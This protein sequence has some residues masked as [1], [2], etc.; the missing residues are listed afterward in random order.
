MRSNS[1]NSLSAWTEY[2][3]R[4]DIIREHAGIRDSGIAHRLQGTL[5]LATVLQPQRQ[6]QWGRL[7]MAVYVTAKQVILG[8]G[9]TRAARRE[10]A[11][12]PF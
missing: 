4:L 9:H 5:E 10:E 3:D 11:W 8:D 2:R 6:P 1:A 7:T 12:Y